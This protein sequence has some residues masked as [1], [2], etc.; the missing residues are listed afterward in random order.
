MLAINVSF[1]NLKLIVCSFDH[2]NSAYE[3]LHVT[4]M[5]FFTAGFLT[6]NVNA[7]AASVGN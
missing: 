3:N 6:C 2:G 4:K 1:S 7:V 5:N